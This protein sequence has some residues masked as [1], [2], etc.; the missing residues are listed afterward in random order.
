MLDGQGMHVLHVAMEHGNVPVLSHLLQEGYAGRMPPPPTRTLGEETLLTL[1][2]E[3]SP[4]DHTLPLLLPLLL[5]P[6]YAPEQ[7]WVWG[8]NDVTRMGK[9]CLS[10]LVAQG[11]LPWVARLVE[12]YGA[13]IH[14][15]P[16]RGAAG[17]ARLHAAV[18]A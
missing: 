17:G 4:V 10:S 6:Q 1:A 8:V 12:E 3:R 5:P 9:T 14:A 16:G 11:A 13:S 15:P 7:S 2:C 18:G